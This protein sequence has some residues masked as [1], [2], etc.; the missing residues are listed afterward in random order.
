MGKRR[1]PRSSLAKIKEQ[2]KDSKNNEVTE[3]SEQEHGVVTLEDARQIAHDTTVLETGCTPKEL[4]KIKRDELKNIRKT[5][6]SD[7]KVEAKWNFSVG[8]LVEFQDRYNK[9]MHIGIVIDFT[10]PDSH[11]SRKRAKNDGSVLLYS[12]LG[13]VWRKP[14]VIRKVE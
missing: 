4:K 8:D 14:A 10:S 5:F 3:A 1:I 6:K 2:Y 13:R 7:K 11:G 12:S 9:V